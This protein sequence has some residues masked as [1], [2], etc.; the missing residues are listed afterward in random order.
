MYYDL[1]RFWGSLKNFWSWR[2]VRG[3]AELQI[4]TK[5]TYFM[6][7][8]VPILAGTWPA[9]RL[10]VNSHNDAVIE[11]TEVLKI[12]SLEYKEV[13]KSLEAYAVHKPG[14][15]R[16]DKS[17]DLNSAINNISSTSGKFTTDVE[18][19]TNDFLPKTIKEPSLPWT[20]AAAFFASLLAVIAHLL[21]QLSAPE[22]LRRFTLDDFVKDKKED[23]SKHPTEDALTRAREY[24]FTKEG[25]FQSEVDDSRLKRMYKEL[26]INLENSKNQKSGPSV[27]S[28]SIGLK[29]SDLS[30]LI[31][32]LEQPEFVDEGDID[33]LNTL[34]EVYQEKSEQS[35]AAE[36]EKQ[37]DMATIERGA[38]A[39]YLYWASKNIFIAI[40]TTLI[41]GVSV[42]IIFE[43]ILLQASQIVSMA[44]WNGLQDLF[45]IPE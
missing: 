5:A 29:L 44:Q 39:E 8:F 28:L 1:L 7:I 30:K 41:Y 26:R 11:A 36:I 20:W 18:S 14:D 6:L 33:L 43:I 16:K 19:F 25:R 15:L 40:L 13:M 37:K 2:L 23:F 12:Y 34:L 10:Y 17:K 42:Y 3:V 24:A 27:R 38:V 31:E 9:V 45:I 4:L 32:M 22:I 35:G 21:Y